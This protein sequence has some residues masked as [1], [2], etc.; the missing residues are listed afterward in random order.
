MAVVFHTV[1]Y[2]C[3]GELILVAGSRI[4]LLCLF[5]RVDDICIVVGIFLCCN[6]VTALTES[7]SQVVSVIF[8]V[9]RSN[10]ESETDHSI[11]GFL[12]LPRSP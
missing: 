9:L 6:R 1:Q 11:K 8:D 5:V 10:L 2:L 4:Q 12:F 7:R 3:Y